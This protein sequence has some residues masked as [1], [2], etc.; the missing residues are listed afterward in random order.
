MEPKQKTSFPVWLTRNIL[1]LGLVSLFTDVS[2][3]M[4]YSIIP[5]FLKDVLKTSPFFI[6]LIEA[7]AESTASVLKSFS[8][9]ISDRLGKR[10]ILIFIGYTFS[11]V[12]KPLLA[13]STTWWHVLMIRFS[14]R[15]GKGIRSSPR[16]ALIAESTKS[17]YFGR[18]YGFHKALDNLGAALGPALAFLIL[19]LFNQNYRLVFGLAFIPALV[20]ILLILFGVKDIIVKSANT[21]SFS[22]G[23]LSPKFK[24]FLLIMVIFT[25]GNSS[26]AFLIL[27]ARDIGIAGKFIPLLWLAFNVSNFLSAYPA[28]AVSD[29]I[30][31]QK[32]IF[33][34]FII[35]C[36]SYGGLAFN[37]LPHTVWFLF[38]F[39]GLYYGFSEGNLKAF[40][41]DLTPTDI[42]GTAFGIY[43]T[44]V[45]VTLL[46]ANL[47]MGIL[48]QKIGFR[49]ALLV[50]SALSLISGILLVTLVR[51]EKT[52]N[53]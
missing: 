5:V 46:P 15:L 45:G 26:D 6:G 39:Y 41:A 43:Y 44:A 30:G 16:D 12:V 38:I 17:E 22:F 11:T 36:L 19:T 23:K 34:G 42:R 49:H 27:R 35:F 7:I 51:T 4:G 14:D 1:T 37:R 32:T 3:E 24:V 8:G 18:T 28:G 48:W 53:P 47:L 50:G 20:A 2:T 31:R 13:L 29:R 40:V 52:R 9:Y 25:L 10:K 21:F 33:I